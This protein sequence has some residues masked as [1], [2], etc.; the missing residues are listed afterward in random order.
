MEYLDSYAD[1]RL[2]ASCIYCGAQTETR[3]HC[4][5]RVLLDEP[6]PENLPVV[7]ACLDCNGGFSLDEE[8]FACVV[9]CA[10]AG[11]IDKVKRTKV[12]RLLADNLSLAARLSAASV[13][14]GQGN[15]GLNVEM[16]RV[17]NVVL[18][19]ARGHAAYEAAEILR[20]AP[21]HILIDPLSTLAPHARRHFE[22]VPGTSVWPEV[23]TRAM[24]RL[25]V[26]GEDVTSEG[27][28]EVQPN[29]YRYFVIAAGSVM[30]RIVVSEYLACEVIWDDE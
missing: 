10:R 24:Q 4:P 1:S 5:S 30:V 26:C 11:A 23:G 17:T 18:K 3:D 27:W 21:S 22:T 20:H 25:L 9:E 6:Y 19:L 14:R 16:P 8:Y 7:P 29:G 2:L 12:A 13:A 28:I 15:P